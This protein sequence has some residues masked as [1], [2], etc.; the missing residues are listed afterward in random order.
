MTGDLS[1]WIIGHKIKAQHWRRRGKKPEGDRVEQGEKVPLG[2]IY[3]VFFEIGLFS[4]GGGLV[5][6]I[7]RE[8]VDIRKWMTNE[9]FLS[10][11]A[12][13]QIM[14]GVNSTNTAIYVGQRLRGLP[15]AA[16]ALGAMLTGPFC[17]VLLAAVFYQYLLGLPGFQ[18][19]MVGVAAAAI[20]MLL[21]TGI[22]SAK[23][24][25]KGL[26]P[27]LMMVLTFIAVGIL[28]YP[29]IPVVC[30]MGPISVALAFWRTPSV[31]E[32]RA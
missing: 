7:H 19:A 5:A 9:E 11:V 14:P 28:R 6:W 4:F 16:T 24:T 26:V 2:A 8:A 22:A 32:E 12:L 20:G 15:G 30:V 27:A 29:L 31:P 21:R 3:R 23:M 10:G 17:A 1:R 13:T 18:E 25:T